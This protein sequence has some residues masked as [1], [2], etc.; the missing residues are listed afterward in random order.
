MKMG[1]FDLHRPKGEYS[2]IRFRFPVG[3]KWIPYY[4]PSEYKVRPAHWDNEAKC[5]I[6]DARRNGDI[7]GNPRLKTHLN[8]VNTEIVNT[9][10]TLIDILQEYQ[11]K[12][13][14]LPR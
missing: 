9:R 7:K 12:K 3:R 11:R 5:A 10:N 14:T 2:L 6:I 4:L 13:I 8:N 1:I